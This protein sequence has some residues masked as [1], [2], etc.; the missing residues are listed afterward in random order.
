MSSSRSPDGLQ[1][2]NTNV[3]TRGVP[4]WATLAS[5][6]QPEPERVPHVGAPR[7]NDLQGE[8]GCRTLISG[9]HSARDQEKSAGA[10]SSLRIQECFIP[11]DVKKRIVA[12]EKK[13]A[14]P[15]R[16]ETVVGHIGAPVPQHFIHAAQAHRGQFER[17]LETCL[18]HA[19]TRTQGRRAVPQS[20]PPRHR[21]NAA[22]QSDRCI[23]AAFHQGSRRTDAGAHQQKRRPGPPGARSFAERPS[24]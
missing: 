6:N 12:V 18:W 21:R 10:P 4:S 17:T 9:H 20:S 1:P 11:V 16:D 24:A 15:L 7:N 14:A 3:C 2:R 13:C 23:P 5:C 8:V 19:E 22:V